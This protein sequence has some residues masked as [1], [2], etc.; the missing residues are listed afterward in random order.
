M[1]TQHSNLQDLVVDEDELNE[2]L[3]TNTLSPY[4]RLGE[5]K[6]GLYPKE[7]FDE[8]HFLRKTTVVL[9]AQQARH[10]LG[11]AEDDVLTPSEIADLSKINKNTVYPA[12]SELHERGI[13]E[14]ENGEYTIAPPKLQKAKEFIEEGD[15]E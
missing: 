5:N 2:E 13:A 4:I 10:Q 3:L 15:V 12:V 7:E 11:M 8:L 1:S 6:G 9:L 14:K